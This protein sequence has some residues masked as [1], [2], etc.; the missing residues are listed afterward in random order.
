[1]SIPNATLK[2][3]IIRGL[4]NAFHA[5]IEQG[6]INQ[7]EYDILQST[8]AGIA[9]NFIT[10]DIRQVLSSRETPQSKIQVYRALLR[11]ESEDANAAQT[12]IMKVTHGDGVNTLKNEVNLY[13][14]ELKS[15]Q[16][17]CVPR[18]IHGLYEYQ[19]H[20]WTHYAVMVLED[21]GGRLTTHLGALPISLA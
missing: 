16:G 15:L 21:C 19:P 4:A 10:V 17:Q 7:D 20:R 5:G 11:E 8:T 13:D 2:F 1:M 3:P 6:P 18:K 12:V 9:G 14:N